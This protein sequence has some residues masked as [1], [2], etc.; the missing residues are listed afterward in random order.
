MFFRLCRGNVEDLI[1]REREHFCDRPNYAVR[2][3][4]WAPRFMRQV[5]EALGYLHSQG[6]IYHDIK[7]ANILYDYSYSSDR[8]ALVDFDVADFGLSIAAQEAA[9]K[10]VAGT[11]FYMPPEAI[12]TG[13]SS[14]VFVVWSLGMT[15]GCILGY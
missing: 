4:S 6:I 7:P 1:P 11:I 8:E 10:G 12:F 5:P 14:P 15:L 13:E 3:P 9:G 2:P